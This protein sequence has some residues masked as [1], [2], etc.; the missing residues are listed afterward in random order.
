MCI[1]YAM[2]LTIILEC[3]AWQFRTIRSGECVNIEGVGSTL[4]L[5]LGIVI[6]YP[7]YE[8]ISMFCVCA[9]A[10]DVRNSANMIL[11]TTG[12]IGIVVN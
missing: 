9:P 6:T 11:A 1:G 8:N 12:Y 5:L 7:K 4:L 3:Y 10:M 2:R